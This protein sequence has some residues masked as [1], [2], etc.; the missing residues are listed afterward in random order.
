MATS[1]PS[2][3]SKGTSGSGGEIKD[4]RFVEEY[5]TLYTQLDRLLGEGLEG[6]WIYFE[7]GEVVAVGE[8]CGDVYDQVKDREDF[9]REKI[10]LVG[11]PL[12]FQPPPEEPNEINQRP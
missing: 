4:K 9:T 6:K 5:T 1:D 8:E 10:L 2:V 11:H 12:R 3:V 7:A